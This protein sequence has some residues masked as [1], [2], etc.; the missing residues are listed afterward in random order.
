MELNHFG[1]VENCRVAGF[2]ASPFD[3]FWLFPDGSVSASGAEF[4]QRLEHWPLPACQIIKP[5]ANKGWVQ[6]LHLITACAKAPPPLRRTPTLQP[7]QK[8]L[9][10]YSIFFHY[11]YFP[12]QLIHVLFMLEDSF[13]ESEIFA[14]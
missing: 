7:P 9:I 6:R 2:T 4:S 8:G 10:L 14:L 1:G 3:G 11:G 5:L 12:Y 13:S